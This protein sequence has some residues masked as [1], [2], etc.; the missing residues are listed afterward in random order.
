MSTNKGISVGFVRWKELVPVLITMF[1]IVVTI[2]VG[3][4]YIHGQ[5]PH[6]DAVPRAEFN[7][8]ADSVEDHF[9]RLHSQID[10]LQK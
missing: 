8:F 10:R 3:A 9:D 2:A 6:K 5:S 4:L 7:R 1:S